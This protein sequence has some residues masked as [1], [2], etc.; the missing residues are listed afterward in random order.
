MIY[1]ALSY[2]THLYLPEA[3]GIPKLNHFPHEF[4]NKQRIPHLH[5]TVVDRL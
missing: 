2:W 5:P 4:A 3:L 1:R